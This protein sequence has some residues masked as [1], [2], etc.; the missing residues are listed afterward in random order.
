MND[1]YLAVWTV[2]VVS[3]SFAIVLI[4]VVGVWFLPFYK[5]LT[6]G[7]MIATISIII[8]AIYV[9]KTTKSLKGPLSKLTL[10]KFI[11]DTTLENISRDE[12]DEKS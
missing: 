5:A 11:T 9:S 2:I 3:S 1:K 12:E 4:P 8:I 10:D 7:A 6:F